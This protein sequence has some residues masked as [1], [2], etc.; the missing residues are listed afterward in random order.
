MWLSFSICPLNQNQGK[1]AQWPCALLSAR[2]RRTEI[3]TRAWKGYLHRSAWGLQES[4]TG[5]SHRVW[6]GSL[7]VTTMW[8]QGLQPGSSG[9]AVSGDR[10]ERGRRQ[11]AVGSW[12]VPSWGRSWM[13]DRKTRLSSTQLRTRNAWLQA[14]KNPHTVAWSRRGAKFRSQL[15]CWQI[16]VSG[17]F[18][19][20]FFFWWYWGLNIGLCTCE[21][22][23]LTLELCLQPF[24]L[25]LFWR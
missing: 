3:W 23:A 17:H 24:F 18:F 7:L 21:A 19:S 20:F 9:R 16:L 2:S 12:L 14:R 13:S 22:G 4:R 10:R 6:Q 25:W 1:T 8:D 5:R 15:W 11:V